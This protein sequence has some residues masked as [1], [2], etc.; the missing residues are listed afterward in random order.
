MSECNPVKTPGEIQKKKTNY[1]INKEEIDNRFYREVIGALMYLVVGT[2]PD[3]ANTV[4]RLAQ[5]VNEPCQQDWLAVKRILRYLAGTLKLGIFYTKKDKSMIGYCDA[6]W[7]GCLEDRRSYSGYVFILAG[8]AVR[9]KS[10]K[11]RTVALSSTESEYVSLSEAVKELIYLRGLLIEI[12]QEKFSN[13]ELFI[14][15]WS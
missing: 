5:F 14:D 9:W 3:I 6:D 1:L 10:Q 13:I 11:Q 15:N 7:G 12:E 8:G 2:R 4:S